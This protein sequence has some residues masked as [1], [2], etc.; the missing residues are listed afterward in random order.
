VYKKEYGQ[1]NNRSNRFGRDNGQRGGYQ[2]RSFGNKIDISK[3]INKALPSNA[4][5][6][7]PVNHFQ[8][9][10]IDERL[11]ANITRKGITEPMPIQDQSIPHVLE[12]KDLIGIADTGMGKTLAFL[13]PLINKVVKDRYQKVL[14]IT[15]TRE[16]ALQIDA[17]LYSLTYQLGIYK[18]ACIGG[19]SISRQMS[20]LRRPQDFVIGTPGRLKDLVNRRALRLS[21]YN[22]IVLD[23][24][25]R[26]LD[27]GFSK[28][29]IEIINQ[30]PKPRQSLFF[31][32]TVDSKIESMIRE[33]SNNP[34][35]ISIKRRDTSA[36]VDQDIVRVYGNS[37]KLDTLHD[38]LIKDEVKKTLIFG[39]TKFGVERLAKDLKVRGFKA[40]SIHGNKSQYQRENA[41]KFFKTGQVDILVATDVAARGLDIPNVTHVINYEVPATFEDYIHRIGRTGR[42]N[43]LGKS[44]NI[45]IDFIL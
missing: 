36:S 24:V 15:P 40:E 31:S 4:E 10:N 14:I 26:M 35:T 11:K 16:L 22:N 39:K 34:V 27:M 2:R 12:G 32:A 1:Y 33:H 18:T 25:D 20:F 38:I 41:L 21:D 13:I 17:E 23:E 19:T 8:N 3:F 45:R 29:I 44:V 5:D 28:E 9:L 7:S 6:Y 43:N 42:G 30:L 37:N